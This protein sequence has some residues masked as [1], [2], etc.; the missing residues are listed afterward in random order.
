MVF[1][2]RKFRAPRLWSNAEL[3]KFAH[4]FPGKVLNASA[5]KDEDKEGKTYK[6]YFTKASVYHVSNYETDKRGIQGLK[7]EFFLDL[8]AE[9]PEQYRN[10][11]DVV[12][13][14]TVLEHIYA[15]QKAFTNLCAMS[16]DIV[17]IVV[18]FVQQ[19]HA[20]YGD[21]WRFTPL[22]L[23]KMYEE[24]GVELL[25]IS[26]NQQP[27]TSV[28]LFAIGS[29]NPEKWRGKI[30]KPFT[31]ANKRAFLDRGEAFV[32][33]NSITNHVLYRIQCAVARVCSRIQKKCGLCN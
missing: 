32:G 7:N 13:N 16:S 14:H 21:Y 5:W 23:K 30:G 19:M 18:P 3:R 9:L 28:Y 2:D 26:Y 11:Y 33:C 6:E 1:T 25:Y 17:I 8:T 22:A 31:Y 27:H 4:L 15:Y 24:N 20:A 29:K 12:F 10:A